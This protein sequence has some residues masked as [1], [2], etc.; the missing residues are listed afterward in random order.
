[1]SDHVPRG[2]LWVLIAV[3]LLARISYGLA[4]TPLLPLYAAF[5][6]AGPEMIGFV[7]AAG[8]ITGVILKL[9][10]GA[11]S[12][13]VGRRP[14]LLFGLF[15]FATGPVGYLLV[16]GEWGLVGVRFYHGLA[17]AI[18]G[19]VAMAT[20]AALAMQR[21]GEYLSYLSN[22]KI[23]GA[24][25]GAFLGGLLLSLAMAG[26]GPFSWKH[27]G[28]LL[29]VKSFDPSAFTRGDFQAAY[30]AC[31]VLGAL[32]LL[33]GLLILRRVH[34]PYL[35]TRRTLTEVGLKLRSGVMEMLSDARVL[36]A[37]GSEAVQNLTVGILEHF[38]PVYAVFVAACTP[39][40]AGMLYGGQIVTTILAKPAFG[41][42]SDRK[43]R[44]RVILAGMVIC[45]LPFAA[46]PW[47]TGFWVLLALSLVFGLGEALVTSS[48]AALVGDLCRKQS[49]GAAMGLFG[50]IADG[51]HALGPI[52]GGLLIGIFASGASGGEV[53]AL[54]YRVA[55]GIVAVILFVYSVVFASAMRAEGREPIAEG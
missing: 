26:D 9:P 41:R 36:L 11:I 44:K 33:L 40:E 35:E 1:M 8:T 47:V 19:P 23:A 10:S 45:S 15:V 42:W 14:L 4:R 53:P 12:D 13:V 6:G 52:L 51:G 38:L 55:F 31:A 17:T 29:E 5:L 20:V 39:F 32:A 34:E 25:L 43:G 54:P 37:S 48:S 21:R 24:L 27:V 3:D 16:A 2:S 7:G 49:L 46:I 28:D 50:T 22:S 30:G 18:F